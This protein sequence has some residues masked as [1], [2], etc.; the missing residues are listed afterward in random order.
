MLFAC[1]SQNKLV[2]AEYEI[3]DEIG[4]VGLKVKKNGDILIGSELIASIS[5]DGIVKN[6]NH[7]L[8]ATFNNDGKL[9]DKTGETLVI[10]DDMGKIHN[11]SSVLMYWSKDGKLMKDKKDTGLRISPAN[12]ILF[13]SAS[14]ILYLY[15]A[16]NHKN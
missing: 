11:S 8:L 7:E 1:N 15:M 5:E 14:V 10:I 2:L 16:L 4:N 12:P 6:K 3:S 13:E 9:L